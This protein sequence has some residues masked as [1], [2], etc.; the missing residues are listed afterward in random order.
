MATNDL[1][2]AN[3]G[4]FDPRHMYGCQN[5]DNFRWPTIVQGTQKQLLGNFVTTLLMPGI[6]LLEWGEEQAYYALDNTA[7]NYVF[8]RQPMSSATAWQDHGCYTVGNAKFATWPDG[9]WAFAC[10]D[11][12]NSLDHRDPSHPIRN[13]IAA[14]Y[15][16]RQRYPVLNDGFYLETIAQ[17][18]H[19]VYLPGSLGTATVTGLWSV[20][21]AG[22]PGVQ[23][24]TASG[25]GLQEVW[26][27]MHNEDS[28]VTYSFDCSSSDGGLLAPYDKGTIVR[29]L[30]YPYE[31]ITLG[32]TPHPLALDNKTNVYGCIENITL[33]PWGFKMF[34]PSDKWTRPLPF[35]TKFNPGHDARILSAGN[36][37]A[38]NLSIELL[39]SDEMDCYATQNAITVTSTTEDDLIPS[40][41]DVTCQSVNDSSVR[42]SEYT[43]SINVTNQIPAVWKITGNIGNV[44]DG[45]HLLNVANTTNLLGNDSTNAIHHFLFRV[46]TIDNPMVFPRTANYS[47]NLFH[48]ANNGTLYIAHKAAGADKFR[49]STNWGS[50][51]SEW[52]TYRAGNYTI[53]EMD[54]SGTKA[55]RWSGQHVQVEYWS[56]KTGSSNHAQQGDLADTVETPRRWPHVFIHGS[57]NQYG[58]DSG[59]DQTMWQNRSGIWQYNFM[60]EWPSELQCNVWGSNP[61]GQ[62]DLTGAFGDVDSDGVLDRLSP[63]SLLKNVVNITAYPPYPYLA[64]HLDVNDATLQYYLTPMGSRSR[65]MAIYTMLL[66]LPMI[67][68]AFGVWV[69]LWF[70]YDVKFN[71][72]GRSAKRQIAPILK[73]TLRIDEM[74]EKL[75]VERWISNKTAEITEA[76]AASQSNVVVDC[77][78]KKVLI[79]TMEYDIDDWAIKIKIGGLGVMAQTMSKHL[80]HLDLIWVVPCVSGIE[81][82]IDKRAEP[83]TVM[84][85]DTEHTIEVQYHKLRNIT[86]VLLDA[87]TFRTQT[88]ENPYPAR[89]DDMDSAIYY[90]A[91]NSCIAEV[92]RRFPIDLYH[93]NDYHGA[94][95]PLHIL[96]KVIPCCLSLHNAEFQGLWS[97]RTKPEFDELCGIYN[98]KPEV[99]VKYVQFGEVFNLLHAGASY[100]RVWQKGYGAAGVSQKYGKRSFARY[101]ILWGLNKVAGLPNPDPTDIDS[102]DKQIPRLRNIAIDET[103]EANR[104]TLRRQAQEWANLKVDPDAELFVF[105]GRWS[106]QKGVDLIADVFPAIL[107]EHS[108]AQLI[109]IGPVIDLYGKFAALKLERLMQIYPNRVYSKPEFTTLPPFIFSGAEFALI[110]SRDEPFGLVA[111]EFGRKGALGVGARVGGLGNMPG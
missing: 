43:G 73:N 86:Y 9:S 90:S 72:F 66:L 104:P 21:R 39:F 40:L 25:Q 88:K 23:D 105:V 1:I 60:T 58:Y 26:Q 103:F 46:G 99:V 79:A 97:I 61:S 91:W 52:L 11:E 98:L 53:E 54:W 71:A 38:Q 77:K 70:F 41:S 48:R 57:F 110:P 32:P 37:G 35:I 87:P 33:P 4:V 92:I 69:Y 80:D 22:W 51:W 20:R 27:L 62:P 94:V 47:S 45:I 42:I 89:M 15:T 64:Y 59:L 18:T 95:A 65:Q 29:N 81:Y 56:Q 5:Q 12:W 31:E 7:S 63:V 30:F 19:P 83:I 14:M 16:M 55:Q 13:L 82:P 24:F 44:S 2:N 28:E 74:K 50:T 76:M 109:C 75:Q 101:P 93:I 6:P 10:H 102:W 8:G 68:G 100:L 84:I 108:N 85:L 111:V 34:V 96:P 3:T 36:G 78:R 106:M 17:Q 107:E 49:Y 67:T